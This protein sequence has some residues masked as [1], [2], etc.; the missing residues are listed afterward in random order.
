[1]SY[2]LNDDD[3]YYLELN[4]SQRDIF[5]NYMQEI[6]NYTLAMTKNKEHKTTYY[7]YIFV[8]GIEVISHI[9]M[10]ILYYTKNVK[11]SSYYIENVS[12]QYSE[13]LGHLLKPSIANTNFSC[14]EASLLL[15]K[16]SI[17]KIMPDKQK[18]T[19]YTEAE[20]K[21]LNDV[22]YFVDTFNN[23][24]YDIIESNSHQFTDKIMKF[25][26]NMSNLH[27]INV[28]LIYVL[29]LINNNKLDYEKS[30]KLCDILKANN[31]VTKNDI[32]KNI[33]VNYLCCL[34]P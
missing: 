24:L 28:D 13:L 30:I 1:M 33:D 32:D 17:Y 12:S 27:F 3:S 29:L 7:K 4:T 15:L 14:K 18:Q 34:R 31:W 9:F 20:L 2:L 10:I 19:I 6:Y 11:V 8:K 21:I 25:I 5:K 16:N 22:R 26:S 23:V